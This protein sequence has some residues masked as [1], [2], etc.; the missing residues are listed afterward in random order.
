M[1]M[2]P[3]SIG[4]LTQLSSI[5]GKIASCLARSDVSHGASRERLEAQIRQL[6]G[7][8]RATL[9]GLK[10]DAQTVEL[11]ACARQVPCS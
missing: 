11:F 6:E 3:F 7:E 2:S 1:S 5:N 9:K 8:K 4:G 10:L